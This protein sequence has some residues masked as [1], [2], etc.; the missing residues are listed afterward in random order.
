MKK[1]LP[2]W[3][4][5][6]VTL[7][8]ILC[9]AIRTSG[10]DQI[11]PYL[12]VQEETTICT[13]E[14]V[15]CIELNPKLMRHEFLYK[16]NL[17]LNEV[18]K[19]VA[20]ISN[21]LIR[22]EEEIQSLPIDAINYEESATALRETCTELKTILSLYN[23]DLESLLAEELRW[24]RKSEEYPIATQVWLYMKNNFGWSDIVCAG[25][26]GNIMAEIGGG[27]LDFSD[28]NHDDGPYG[29]FQWLGQR[30]IDIKQIYGTMPSIE[31]QLEFMYDELYG[32]DEVIQQVTDW[33]RDRIFNASTLEKVAVYFCIYF[34]RPGN[35]GYVRKGYARIA[36]DY[37]TE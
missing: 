34:E 20:D 21:Y 9:C 32:T 12:E 18:K 16:E 27:T 13:E 23:S 11:G 14:P 31:E 4:A 26:M 29:M 36:Y 6:L 33:Q 28:W 35:S 30:E 8:L 24:Q 19:I 1:R 25:I 22:L 37:F 7:A 3:V 15:I 17:S 10:N 5:V 2:L